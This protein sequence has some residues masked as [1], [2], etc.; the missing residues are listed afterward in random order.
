MLVA[1]GPVGPGPTPVSGRGSLHLRA[2][3]TL[4]HKVAARDIATGE[5]I[6]KYGAPIGSAT[7][8]IAAGEHVHVDNIKSDYT[9]TYAL[10]ATA[11]GDS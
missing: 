11:G 2:K 4:G 3:V 6:M 10:D 5:R 7:A 1:T 9:P 8:E